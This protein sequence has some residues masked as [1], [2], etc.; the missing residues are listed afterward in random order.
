MSKLKPVFLITAGPTREYLDPVRFFSN[1]STGKMGYALARTAR[2]RGAKVIL[3][4]GPVALRAPGGVRLVRVESANEMRREVMRRR[5]DVVI[6]AA[7]V[8]DYRPEKRLSRKM[9]KGSRQINVPMA[10]T[11][12]ILAELGRKK[13]NR[14]L[15]GFAAETGALVREARRKLREKDLDMIVA[16]DVFRPDAGFASDYNRAVIIDRDGNVTRLARMRK[17][18]LARIIIRRCLDLYS[19]PAS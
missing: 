14:I 5:A 12:D 7:A 10:R 11:G 17:D 16:N 8:A 1:P 3:V 2:D 9:K 19:S 6:M 15:V 13:G 18:A 4:S